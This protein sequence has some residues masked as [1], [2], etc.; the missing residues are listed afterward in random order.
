MTN[1]LSVLL[2]YS[3]SIFIVEF[4]LL[5]IKTEKDILEVPVWNV[6]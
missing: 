4:L 3:L 6:I 5:E 2:F 1:V